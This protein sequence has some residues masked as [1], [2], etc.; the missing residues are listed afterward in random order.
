V[1]DWR[2]NFHTAY[3]L[4]C[5]HEYERLSGDDSFA[6]NIDAGLNYYLANFFDGGVIP[7]YYD[8]SLYPVDATAC[9]QSILTLVRFGRVEQAADVAAWCVEHLSLPD[10]AFKY[11][12]HRRYENSI[13][14]MRWSVAWMYL[15]LSRLELSLAGRD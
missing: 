1:R 5:L 2:D 14:Y 11:Q 7:R 6:P 12:I 15:A 4:D 9:A 10:G 13:P 3:I 8:Q